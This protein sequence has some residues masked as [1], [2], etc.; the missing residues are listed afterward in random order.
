MLRSTRF[1]YLSDINKPYIDELAYYPNSL[2][3]EILTEKI[4]THS[5]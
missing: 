4:N 1:W 3:P 2:Y 5:Q